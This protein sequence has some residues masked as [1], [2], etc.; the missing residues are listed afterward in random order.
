MGT[1]NSINLI[2]PGLVHYNG[3]GLFSGLNPGAAGNVATS[4]GPGVAPSFQPPSAFQTLVQYKRTSFSTYSNTS[5][6]FSL[7]AVPTTSGGAFMYSVSITPTNSNNLLFIQVLAYASS[8]S[9]VNEPIIALFQDSIINALTA[10]VLY[11]S[12]PNPGP[13][14][15]NHYMTAGTISP[16]TFKVY[17]GVAPSGTAY[18]NGTPSAQLFGGAIESSII[19]WELKV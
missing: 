16:T 1:N 12:G 8:N 7:T 11:T 5:N 17:L 2:S 15:L 18:I 14:T 10:G 3:N 19:V 6:A 13:I 9:G 4:N